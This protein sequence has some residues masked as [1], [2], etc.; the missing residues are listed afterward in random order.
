MTS[1]YTPGTEHSFADIIFCWIPPG[2]FL[3][4]SPY[5]EED[6]WKFEGPQQEIIFAEGYWMSKYEI[7][8]RQWRTIM[9]N[10]PSHF[11]GK[12]RPVESVSWCDIRSSG[13]YL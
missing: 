11:K 6:R 7:T 13:G 10:N 9:G 12:N 8:Q 4:G 2:K 1:L 5:D 3:M